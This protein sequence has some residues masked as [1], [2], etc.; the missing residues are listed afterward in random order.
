M[1]TPKITVKQYNAFV[2]AA[3]KANG[4]ECRSHWFGRLKLLMKRLF[5]P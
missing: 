2:A 1:T 3:L 5:H 4:S